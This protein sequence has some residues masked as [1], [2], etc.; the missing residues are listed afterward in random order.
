MGSGDRESQWIM[1]DCKNIRLLDVKVDGRSI[2]I[3]PEDKNI[4][5]L[6]S[7]AKIGIPAPCYLAYL[8]VRNL[9]PWPV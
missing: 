6:A 4:V 1:I 8:P 7:R 9:N 3:I 5:D 2:H